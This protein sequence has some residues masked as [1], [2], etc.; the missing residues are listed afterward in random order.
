MRIK[1]IL[2]QHRR[3]FHA[4]YECEHCGHIKKDTGYD[5]AHFHKNVIPD[6]KCGACGK[7]SPDN[8]RPLATKHADHAVV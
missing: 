6:K 3:D 8:Y 5:D 1:T 7:T 4:I 2:S